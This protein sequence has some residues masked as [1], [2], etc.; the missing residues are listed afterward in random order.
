VL[1]QK[2]TQ[3][4]IV[5]PLYPVSL[6]VSSGPCPTNVPNLIGLTVEQVETALANA[7]LSLGNV[8]YQCSNQYDNGTV[9]IQSTVAN[10][11]VAE[12]STVDITVSQDLV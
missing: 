12:G 11:Q 2:P 5:A 3:N 6:T 4:N 9:F 7:N 8:S 10:V 1:V